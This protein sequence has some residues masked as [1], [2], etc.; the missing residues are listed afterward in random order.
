MKFTSISSTET[1]EAAGGY[2]EAVLVNNVNRQLFI[3]GQ[4]P[5]NAENTVPKLFEDQARLAWNN[6]QM[7]LEAAD[8]GLENIVK[9]TTFLSNRKF[10]SANSKIRQ[11]VLGDFKPALTVII[12]DIYDE[13]WLLEIEAVAVD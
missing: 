6:I 9:H 11:E 4:I 8:M 13:E 5:M 1:P 12:A 10:T 3:S 2:S 7:L